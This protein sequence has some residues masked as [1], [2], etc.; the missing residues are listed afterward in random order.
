MRLVEAA[1]GGRLCALY[2]YSSA[3]QYAQY[4]RSMLIYN[5]CRCFTLHSIYPITFKYFSSHLRSMDS[6]ARSCEEKGMFVHGWLVGWLCL[7][8][9]PLTVH[10]SIR[11]R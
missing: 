9:I 2:C 5:L 10:G 8:Y 7:I 6:T 11:Y 1:Q 3:I 4:M